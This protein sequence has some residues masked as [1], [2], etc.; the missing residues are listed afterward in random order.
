M[1]K[2]IV[3][4]C[5]IIAFGL[6]SQEKIKACEENQGIN[7]SSSN[8]VKIISSATLNDEFDT[9]NYINFKCFIKGRNSRKH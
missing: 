2:I 6:V 3:F 5:L 4:I 8:E 9:N 7:E 1:K